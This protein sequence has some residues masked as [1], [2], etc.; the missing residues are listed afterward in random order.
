M[1]LF[2]MHAT[3]M[4]NKLCG[5][6]NTRYAPP[7]ASGDLNG[8]P[9]RPGDSWPWNRRKMSAVARTTFLPIL[10]FLRL[11]VVQLWAT[12]HQS[13]W[14]HDLIALTSLP[15]PLTLS[16]NSAM[17]V[18]VL[19]P[20]AKYEVRRSPTLEDVTHFRLCSINQLVSLTSELPT[21]E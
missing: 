11:F 6:H 17:R 4:I 5:R 12:V 15:W 19:H 14:Q 9:E 2:V 18:I 13:N 16:N 7:P 10:V 3:C 8:H 20:S 21:P 1:A